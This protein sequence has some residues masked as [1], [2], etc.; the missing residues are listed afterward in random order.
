MPGM[1]GAT[2]AGNSTII[3]QFHTAL[4]HQGLLILLVLVLLFVAWNALRSQQYRRAVAQ[5]APYPPPRPVTSPEP[6][7]VD[8]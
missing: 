8:C 1:G 7:R 5:G 6:R 3:R 4:A 2:G